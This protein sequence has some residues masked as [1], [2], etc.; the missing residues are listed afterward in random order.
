MKE[1]SS[2]PRVEPSPSGN[3][4]PRGPE[5]HTL[6][7]PSLARQLAAVVTEF[8]C[9]ATLETGLGYGGSAI[10]IAR[11]HEQRGRGVHIAIDPQ[12]QACSSHG[13]QNLRQA[14]L[15]HRV[16]VIASPSEVAL[17][18][19]LSDGTEIDFALIAG[20]KRFEDAFLEFVYVDRM[21][22]TGGIL[23]L[24]GADMDAMAAVLDY[25][26]RARF[27]E[28][29]SEPG[30]ELAVMRKIGRVRGEETP[31][32]THWQY[33]AALPAREPI[34]ASTSGASG[35]SVA[36]STG[37]GRLST[38]NS[39]SRE[40]HLARMRANELQTRVGELGARLVDA[41]QRCAEL[42]RT[43]AHLADRERELQQAR[44]ETDSLRDALTDVREELIGVREELTAAKA[45]HERAEHWLEC[46]KSSASW[47][48]TGPLRLAKRRTRA[49]LGR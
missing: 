48:I 41:E 12:E 20:H 23:A 25:A 49:L 27:Y 28:P 9:L 33:G 29:R 32:P 44:D 22:A 7:A 18:E 21:L 46:M 14:G 45:A 34:P 6:I 19:L 40:L 36:D 11:T 47:R 16:R 15:L 17:P 1:S 42:P 30:A 43:N 26:P 2:P 5:E 4:A 10:A 31:T 24:S 13:L 8:G 37:P 38:T 35:I 39:S 3:R